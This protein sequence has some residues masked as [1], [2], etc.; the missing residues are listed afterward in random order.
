MEVEHYKCRFLGLTKASNRRKMVTKTPLQYIEV[1]EQQD[2]GI[3]A[4]PDVY[5]IA[6]P[7]E[8]TGLLE[9]CS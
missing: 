6:R 2:M 7:G 1:W 8:L 9:S 5:R 4:V 3:V